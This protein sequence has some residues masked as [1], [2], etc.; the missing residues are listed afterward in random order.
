MTWAPLF[1]ASFAKTATFTIPQHKIIKITIK[2]GDFLSVIKYLYLNIFL[3]QNVNFHTQKSTYF[4][5]DAFA[6]KRSEDRSLP[7]YLLRAACAVWF[8]VVLEIMQMQITP[9]RTKG[10]PFVY[11]RTSGT[12]CGIILWGKLFFCRRLLWPGT[13]RCC[14]FLAYSERHLCFVSPFDLYLIAFIVTE[15][16]VWGQF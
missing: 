4:W 8:H 6:L 5:C 10:K 16:P 1:S 15:V 7:S 12:I 2:V 9:A 11:K 13:N 3:T 14:C